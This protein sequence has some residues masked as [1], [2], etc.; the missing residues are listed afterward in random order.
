MSKLEQYYLAMGVPPQNITTQFSIAAEHAF[1]TADFG[2]RCDFKGAPY[3]NNCSFDTAGAIL[4]Q[5]YQGDIQS[6][7]QAWDPSRVIGFDQSKFVEI[8]YSLRSAGLADEGYLFVP[9]S[10]E[11]GSCALHVALHG[12]L[13]DWEEN[14]GLFVNHTLNGWAEPNRIIV[15]YPQARRTALN[16]KGC[17][18]WWGYTG[19]DYAS[20]LGAQM[21]T[22]KNMVDHFSVATRHRTNR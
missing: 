4:K 13:Q 5:L 3:I 2:K 21:R 15:V 8:G 7:T 1:V 9:T 19:L 14:N 18:D 16:P 11:V 20:K 17:F 12:C 10:C 22:I 6:S